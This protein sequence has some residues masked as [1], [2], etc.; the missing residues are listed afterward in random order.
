ML[1]KGNRTT[2]H[3]ILHFMHIV[4]NAMQK[5]AD[6]AP[7]EWNFSFEAGTLT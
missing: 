3:M 4:F 2:S 6:I 1:T 7:P 5:A